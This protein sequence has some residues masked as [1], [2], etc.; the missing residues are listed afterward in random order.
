MAGSE[1]I[2]PTSAGRKDALW[3]SRAALVAKT[4]T[5]KGVG[6]HGWVGTVRDV[7]QPVARGQEK[8]VVQKGHHTAP[9]ILTSVHKGQTSLHRREELEVRGVRDSARPPPGRAEPRMRHE[10]SGSSLALVLAGPRGPAQGPSSPG[11]CGCNPQLTSWNR[12]E[13]RDMGFVFALQ[14][15]E[16]SGKGYSSV[17]A[18]TNSHQGHPVPDGGSYQP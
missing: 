12:G 7:P 14:E 18:L 10:A 13:T 1:H 11:A 17:P 4:F 6:R 9:S 8:G 16:I 5:E 2:S 15:V 3:A